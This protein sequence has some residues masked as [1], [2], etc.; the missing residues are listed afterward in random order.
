M[1]AIA[2]NAPDCTMYLV[3]FSRPLGAGLRLGFMVVAP[4]L[5]RKP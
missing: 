3:A 2:A 4:R 5:G 1:K